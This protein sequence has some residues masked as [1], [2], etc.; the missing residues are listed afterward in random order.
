MARAIQPFA[1]RFDGD[2]LYAVSTAEYEPPPGESPLANLVTDTAAAELMWDAILSSVPDQ[3]APPSLRA[4]LHP[5]AAV[6]KSFA[7]EY[8]F[9][10]TARLRVSVR[11]EHLIAEA[12]G[13]RRV[14][15]IER[16]AT[17]ELLPISG[18]QFGIPGRYPFVLSFEAGGR[19]I[20]NP[21]PWQQVGTRH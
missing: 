11:G 13:T 9:S 20:V 3:P 8:V 17:A 15:A 21:G 10:P 12:T 5:G 14:F 6:L 16:G 2:V 4:D 7:G 18:T 1:T 19:V